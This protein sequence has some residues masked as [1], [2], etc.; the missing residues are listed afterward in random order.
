[1]VVQTIL[2]FKT[3]YMHRITDDTGIFQ[4][5][6]FGVPDRSMGYTTDDNARAL[7]AAVLMYSSRKDSETL[8]LIHTYISFIH[9]A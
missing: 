5:T 7:I 6:K 3:D 1:M 8:N 2:K 9:H 4:H